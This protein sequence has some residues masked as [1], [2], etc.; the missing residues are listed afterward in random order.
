MGLI[1]K[2]KGWLNIGGVKASILEVQHPITT[3]VGTVTGTFE[4]T[5]KSPRKVKK[6]TYRFLVLETKGTG[7]DKEVKE[8]TIAEVSLPVDVSINAG[9]SIKVD[10]E[11]P[12]DMLGLADKMAAKGGVMGAMGKMAKFAAKVGGEKVIR[13]YSIEVACDVEG[14]PV[15]ATSK[16]PIRVAVGD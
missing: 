5:S 12:Y 8:E 2:I 4:M 1:S 9:Q 7:E 16:Y 11:I 6:Y 3:K 15:D 13:D 10:F 14:T